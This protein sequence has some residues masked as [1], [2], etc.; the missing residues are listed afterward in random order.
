MDTLPHTG[1]MI[2]NNNSASNDLADIYEDHVLPHAYSVAHRGRLEFPSRTGRFRNPRCGD[3]VCI[4]LSVDDKGC[5]TRACF[6]SR[7]C[8]TAH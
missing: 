8:L 6:E 5:V 3:E 2:T 1:P 7:G 4:D